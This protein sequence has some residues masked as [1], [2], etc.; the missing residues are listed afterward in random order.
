[1]RR[2]MVS[3]QQEALAA[4]SVRS[5]QPLDRRTHAWLQDVMVAA[6]RRHQG[7][8][9]RLVRAAADGARAAGC[10]WLHVDFEEDLRRFYLEACG[11]TP[12]N[13]G[14]MRL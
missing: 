8:G 12:T 1:M 10:D 7:L 2:R 9:A 5:T 11:F 14:L 6:D 13:A 4:A 3:R